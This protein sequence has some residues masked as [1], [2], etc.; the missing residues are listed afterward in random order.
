MVRQT[1]T[2]RKAFALIDDLAT[3]HEPNLAPEQLAAYWNVEVQ[4]IRKW[5]RVGVLAG[6]RLGSVLRVRREVA[7]MFERRQRPK[8]S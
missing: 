8:A 7:V 5:I 1:R 3:H 6:F 4:T 2:R